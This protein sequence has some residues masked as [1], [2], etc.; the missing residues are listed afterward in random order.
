MRT[1][2]PACL[3][4]ALLLGQPGCRAMLYPAAR[5]FGA[6][7]E[8]ELKDCRAAFGR[9]QAGRG[10][11]RIVVYPACN[12]VRMDPALGPGSAPLLQVKLQAGGFGGAAAAAAGPGLAATPY[13][14]NQLRYSWDRAHAYGAWI[15]A[16]RPEGEFFLFTEVV[17][18]PEGR[19][20]GLHAY[21]LDAS[22][23]VAYHRLMNSHHFGPA[24]PAGQT[25]ALELLLQAFLRDLQRPALEVFPRWGVG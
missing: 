21:V 15:R 25:E 1:P 9:L 2:A 13:G 6:P 18:S 24:G 17:A 14:G 20:H 8:G 7:A 19:I 3:A 23:T 5:A 4:L 10:T 16:A 11:V 22:G 12:P